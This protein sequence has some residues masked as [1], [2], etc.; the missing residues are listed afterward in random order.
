MQ[1]SAVAKKGHLHI[2]TEIEKEAV[3]F[4]V[5]CNLVPMEFT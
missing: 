4:P 1:F 3:G 2:M 5:M